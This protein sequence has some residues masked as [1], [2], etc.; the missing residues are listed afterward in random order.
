LKSSDKIKI[1]T[2][3]I[4]EINL[5]NISEITFRMNCDD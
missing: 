1:W 4:F 2:P 5:L 3:I